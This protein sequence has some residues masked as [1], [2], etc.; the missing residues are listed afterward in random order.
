MPRQSR[1]ARKAD[2]AA[3]ASACVIV[4]GLLVAAQRETPAAAANN[5]ERVELG[6]ARTMSDSGYYVA[7]DL[8]YF[9]D[10]GIQVVMTPFN[11]AAQMIAPLGTGELDVGGGTVSAAFYNAVTRG[12]RVKIVADQASMRPGY[13]YSS[14]L[15]RSDIVDSGRYK[16]FS[17]LK[18]LRVAIGAP[19]TGTAAA[20]NEILKTVGLK[21][22]DVTIVNLGFPEHLSAY[23]NKAID[24]SI[25]NEPTTTLAVEAGVAKRIVGNDQTY[26]NQQTAVVFY[27]E[28]FIRERRDVALRFMR[29]Y[30]R[31]VRSYMAALKGGKLNGTDADK[32]AAALAKYTAIND[33]SL[34]HRIVP[35]TANPNGTV[36][37]TGLR[38]DLA[39]FEEE[40]LIQKPDQLNLDSVVDDSFAKAAVASLGASIG[41]TEG[42]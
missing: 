11:S 29:A 41:E 36:N 2:W 4:L 39:F 27:S 42:K 23:S 26:P 20:L 34:F 30:I 21:Y 3:F 24:A 10:E 14:L 7:D 12:I 31:G 13:G 40:G 5:L 9:R 37:M 35:S 25:T 16:D 28:N 1:E 32:I 22:S 38:Q 6:I 8:G 17:D 15:V 19:G 18:G 33:A